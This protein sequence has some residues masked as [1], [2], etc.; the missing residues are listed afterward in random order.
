[1]ISVVPIL[2]ESTWRGSCNSSTNWLIPPGLRVSPLGPSRRWRRIADL[3]PGL[4]F[5]PRGRNES[6]RRS[7]SIRRYR[8]SR[9]PRGQNN[10]HRALISHAVFLARNLRPHYSAFISVLGRPPLG[11]TFK[12]HPCVLF[13]R[14][15][16]SPL[17]LFL[18]PF[19]LICFTCP[20]GTRERIYLVARADF[21]QSF[22]RLR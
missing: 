3:L 16:F 4:V 20:R 6:F 21:L 14:F 18:F 11:R 17:S 12:R 8:S 22:D 5:G 10:L 19:L 1:M 15:I 13:W 7:Y 2:V 9:R